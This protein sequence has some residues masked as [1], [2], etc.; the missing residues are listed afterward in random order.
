MLRH[1]NGKVLA[2]E[3]PIVLPCPVLWYQALLCRSW[4]NPFVSLKPPR[5]TLRESMLWEAG[6]DFI[7]WGHFLLYFQGNKK[8][9]S[10]RMLLTW[11]LF[12]LASVTAKGLWDSWDASDFAGNTSLVGWSNRDLGIPFSEL[13]GV[14]HWS[15]CEKSL[16]KTGGNVDRLCANFFLKA[17]RQWQSHGACYKAR[18]DWR[19]LE[20]INA[21]RRTRT[22]SVFLCNNFI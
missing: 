13:H 14:S 16:M 10:Q 11:G 5:L 17:Q 3:D 19:S 1:V 12:S 8:Y 6:P 22:P 20:Q 7:N 18:T 15:Q 4:L 9:V 2:Q 21:L